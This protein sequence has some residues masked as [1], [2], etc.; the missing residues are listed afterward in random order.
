MGAVYVD[1][2]ERGSVRI[3]R[4]RKQFRVLRTLA[5][6]DSYITLSYFALAFGKWLWRWGPERQSK[7]HASGKVSIL[8]RAGREQ[9]DG[10]RR[11]GRCWLVVNSSGQ[12]RTPHDMKQCLWG[13]E[14]QHHHTG[15]SIMDADAY[16]GGQTDGDQTTP[17]GQQPCFLPLPF[18]LQPSSYPSHH[19]CA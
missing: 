7:R 14:A 6:P 19:Q 8:V 15:Q 1:I 18:P 17:R 13:L 11:G 5:N 2:H 9:D 4:P 3:G 10:S 16:Q 12:V